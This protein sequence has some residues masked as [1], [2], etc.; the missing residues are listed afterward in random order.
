MTNKR[1]IIV[2]SPYL[3]RGGVYAFVSNMVPYLSSDVIIFQRGSKSFNESLLTKA[4]AFLLLPLRF[5]FSLLEH[6][7]RFIIVNTSLSDSNLIRDGL[8][9]FLSKLFQK[10]V[11]LLIHGFRES[12]LKR[13]V[14]L[15][16]GYFQSDAIIVNANTFKRLLEK[17]GY[18]RKVYTQYNPI[19]DEHFIFATGGNPRDYSSFENIMFFSRIERAKGVFTAIEAFRL[20][21]TKYPNLRLTIAGEGGAL[22]EAKKHVDDSK[23][24]NIDFIGRTFNGPNAK[25]EKIKFLND[26]EIFL[27]PTEHKEGLPMSVL[28]AMAAAQVVITRPVGGLLDLYS[29]CR[30]GFLIDSISPYD[31]SN[32]I[33]EIIEHKDEFVEVRKQNVEFSKINFH[34]KIIAQRIEDII[35]DLS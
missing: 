5:L 9:V 33:C 12:S 15:K 24:Q 26:F 18:K 31:F 10:Q 13:S 32:A 16:F 6:N 35:I 25:E 27:F 20:A 4:T 14:L 3:S 11:L 21:S 8:I 23:I 1:K 30:F 22:I 2:T 7:P 19:P 29:N 17:A 28:E 34:S